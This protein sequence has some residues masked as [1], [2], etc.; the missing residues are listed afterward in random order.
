MVLRELPELPV[1]EQRGER[2]AV[3]RKVDGSTPSGRVSFS[4][5]RMG[6][7]LVLLL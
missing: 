3:N 5:S 1:D 7:C 2:A 4:T 6:I